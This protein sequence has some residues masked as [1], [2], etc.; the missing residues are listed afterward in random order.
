MTVGAGD[1]S[2]GYG[3]GGVSVQSLRPGATL[4]GAFISRHQQGQ[5]R[6]LSAGPGGWAAASS[7][8]WPTP[9]QLFDYVSECISDFLEKHHMKH[10]KLPLGFTFSFPVRHEDIDKVGL[11]GGWVAGGRAGNPEK[12]PAPTWESW[13]ETVAVTCLL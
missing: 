13:I 7:P 3:Q 12:L 1:R 4:S 9:F 5:E 8:L 10:K 11:G 2:H 6:E